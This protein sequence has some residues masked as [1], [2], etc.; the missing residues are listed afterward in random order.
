MSLI[1][2]FGKKLWVVLNF[3]FIFL[4]KE[5]SNKTN[6]NIRIY[7]GGAYKG[8][9]GGPLVKVKRLSTV[10]PEYRYDFNLLYCLS[11][12][13]YLSDT[14]LKIIKRKGIPIVLNQNGVYFSGWYGNGWEDKN[15]K[16]APAYHLSDYI[17]WQSEF[18]KESADNFLGKRDISGEV[19]FNAVDTTKFLP[20]QKQNKEFTFLTTGVFI[21]SMLY[22]L[23]AT[24]EAFYLFQKKYKETQLVIAGYMSKKSQIQIND[25]IFA[26]ELQSKIKIIGSYSQ[27]FAPE[28]Y[29]GADAYIM[30]KYM[31][32]SP[33]VVI[34]AM[35]CGLPII[36]SSTGGVPELVGHDAGVG[37]I[38]KENWE[39]E[40]HAPEPHLVSD[41]M[42]HV[43]TNQNNLS[44][45][46]RSRAVEKFDLQKWMYRHGEVF[47]KYVN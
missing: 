35:A 4:V 27:E 41:A 37:I 11:N 39:S 7:Y 8:D 22:R 32:A 1:K 45:H 16:L 5:K 42:S 9:L 15:K 14:S 10:Y 21:D 47:K 2:Y 3:L 33:N 23:T 29:A 34:E 25:L 28:I 43:L 36:Y 13:P 6:E 44:I 46:A 20:K 24:V 30:L 17:F 40:P 12:F 18:C 19:L 38:L 26:R 31:D